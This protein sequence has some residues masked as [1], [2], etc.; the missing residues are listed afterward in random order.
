M[1]GDDDEWDV[2]V[3]LGPFPISPS[4]HPSAIEFVM[5]QRVAEDPSHLDML[6]DC[7]LGS[8]DLKLESHDKN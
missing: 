3:T 1:D 2:L 6:L 7:K 5:R 8:P 4:W